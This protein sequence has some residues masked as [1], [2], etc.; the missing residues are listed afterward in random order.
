MTYQRHDGSKGRRNN[1][2]GLRSRGRRRQKASFGEQV[3]SLSI[4]VAIATWA[5]TPNIWSGWAFATKSRDEIARV[6][7][8]VYYPGCSE[9][10]AAGATPIY[11]GSP[12]Y[13][14]G[15]DGDNDGIACEAY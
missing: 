4:F 7:Q 5:L 14:P 15:M 10:H 2:H 13:R 12:G 9:A 11:R 8:S 1:V 3:L 6:E